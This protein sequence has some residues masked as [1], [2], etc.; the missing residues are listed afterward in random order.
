MTGRG[1]AAQLPVERV[2][3]WMQDVALPFWLSRGLDSEQGGFVEALA[4]TGERIPGLAKRV[5]VQARQIYVMSH[6]AQLGWSSDKSLAAA[7][8]GYRFLMAHAVH[9][10]GGFVHLLEAD[11]RVRDPQRDTYDHAFILL[12]LSWFYR[13]SKEPDALAAIGRTLRFIDTQL[14]QPDGSFLESLPPATPRRQNPHMHLFEAM[15]SL[16]EATGEKDFL[17]RAGRIFALFTTRFFDAK[18]GVLVEYF[19][20]RWRPMPSPEGDVIE[21]GHH[22]EW[23]WLLDKYERLTGTDTSAPRR[24]LFD[25]ALRHGRDPQTRLLVD[26]IGPDGRKIK[27]TM[28]SWPQTEALKASLVFLQRGESWALA[29]AALFATGLLDR[30]CGVTPAG[31]W[32]DQFSPEGAPLTKNVP[33]STYYHLFLAFA[34]LLRVAGTLSTTERA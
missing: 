21:P 22:C 31:L 11:G 5:R 20:E 2:R 14:A 16:Y 26:E 6:A 1:L 33:A 24:A 29:E 28:R 8:E 12:A 4:L 34:E 9:P 18:R 32:Q 17:S 19:D 23:V 3:A 10:D 15:L 25:F 27:A 30:Y 13:A 7:R